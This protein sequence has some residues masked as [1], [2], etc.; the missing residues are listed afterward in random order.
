MANTEHARVLSGTYS[1][2]VFP[3]HSVLST[4]AVFYDEVWLPYPYGFDWNGV[5]FWSERYDLE[6]AAKLRRHSRFE[7]ELSPGIEDPPVLIKGELLGW[8]DTRDPSSE[9]MV[10]R[11]NWK[12]LQDE[13]DLLFEHGI[14]RTLPPPISS[15][16][17]V[18]EGFRQALVQRLGYPTKQKYIVAEDVISGHVALAIHA[19]YSHKPS[20]ELF[21]SASRLYPRHRLDQINDT[22]TINLAGMVA[23]SLFS[24]LVPRLGDL[25]PEEILEVREYLKDTKQGFTYYIFEQLDAVEDRLT[26][27]DFSDIR[28]AAEKT[29]ERNILPKYT[30]MRRQL[31]AKQTGFWSNVLAAGAKFLQIDATPWTPKF[32]GQIIELFFGPLARTAE[33]EAEALSNANQAF[34]YLAKLET[35]LLE[36]TA[37]R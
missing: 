24:F 3:A 20:P 21:I 18:P 23:E 35:T 1:S 12:R 16:E 22:T 7:S 25:H 2:G 32:Y 13:Y 29:V 37:W 10:A 34:Q 15:A 14:I 31:E 36:T 33:A 26:S 28:E 19:L 4:L 27:G 30:E 5:K 8:G 11:H 17:E 6:A 9:L